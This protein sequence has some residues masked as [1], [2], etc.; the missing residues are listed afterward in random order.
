MGIKKANWEIISRIDPLA[1]PYI[2]MVFNLVYQITTNLEF[3]LTF[4]CLMEFP[5]LIKYHHIKTRI[6]LE[7]ECSAQRPPDH[8]TPSAPLSA[9]HCHPTW[10]GRAALTP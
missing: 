5:K 7:P 10:Q 3:P 8:A 6:P 9:L 2:N 1:E 4:L